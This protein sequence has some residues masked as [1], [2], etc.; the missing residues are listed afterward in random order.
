MQRQGVSTRRALLRGLEVAV[1]ALPPLV[2]LLL[3]SQLRSPDPQDPRG[4]SAL[5]TLQAAR[6]AL[7]AAHAEARQLAA[8]VGARRG[9]GRASDSS[10]AAVAQRAAEATEELRALGQDVE[11]RAAELRA[12]APP[13]VPVECADAG[14]PGVV[15]VA[16]VRN[17][18]AHLERLLQSVDAMRTSALN[19]NVRVVVVDHASS[20]NVTGVAGEWTRAA[21]VESHVVAYEPPAGA[22]GFHYAQAALQGVRWAERRWPADIVFVSDADLILP[23]VLPRL[24]RY[25]VQR[26][27]RML[28]VSCFHVADGA[29]PIETPGNGNFTPQRGFSN[30][31][32]YLSDAVK[33]S[34]WAHES[35][36]SGDGEKP[37][38]TLG[39]RELLGSEIDVV[40]RQVHGCWHMHHRTCPWLESPDGLEPPKKKKTAPKRRM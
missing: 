15:V 39:A 14:R 33:L 1:A 27:T 12:R 6:T 20:E 25:H 2:V 21:G 37:A 22:R 13:V 11:R 4:P 3:V 19:C 40:E 36:N 26:A 24:I 8:A 7:L 16:V 10:A 29:S 5:Q 38:T 31:A 28:A 9:A 34:L 35:L 18:A 17:R 30:I 23:P 32:M